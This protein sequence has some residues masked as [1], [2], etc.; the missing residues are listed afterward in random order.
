MIRIGIIGGSGLDDPDIL[1]NCKK[2]EADTPYGPP[3]S[4][5][6]AGLI[7]DT[8]VLILARHGRKHQYSPLPGEQPGKYICSE[9]GR[10]HAYPCHN[11][12]RQP[13]AG[14]LTGVIL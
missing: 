7:N 12:L 11:R 13:E 9:A 2:I 10:C 4:D 3:S 14:K 6:M 1:E 5:I 8:Q